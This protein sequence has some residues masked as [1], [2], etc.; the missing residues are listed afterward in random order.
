MIT[1]K[2]G[3]CNIKGPAEEIAEDFYCFIY[4]LQSSKDILELFT[5]ISNKVIEELEND[6]NDSSN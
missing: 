3:L 5:N 4:T 6:K 2:E 1:I